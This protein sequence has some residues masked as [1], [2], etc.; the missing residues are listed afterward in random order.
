MLAYDRGD[1]GHMIASAQNKMVS[2]PIK[3]AVKQ[4][5]LVT[6]DNYEYQAAKTLGIYV[7]ASKFPLAART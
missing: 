3:Q 5:K 4:L 1:F 7:G 6:E 2:V